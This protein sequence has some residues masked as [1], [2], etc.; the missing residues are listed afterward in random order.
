MAG[1]TPIQDLFSQQVCLVVDPSPVFL[2]FMKTALNN[3]ESFNLEL[4][5]S[6]SFREAKK[7]IETRKPRIV[8]VEHE[9]DGLKGLSLIEAQQQIYDESS[10]ISVIISQNSE[11]S[12]IA[13]AAEEQVDIFMLK[14]FSIDE[15]QKRLLALI[16]KK[17]NPTEYT[18]KINQARE[19][20]KEKSYS[21]ALDLLSDAKK[22]RDKPALA[23]FYRGDVYRAINDPRGALAEF[24]E[25]R[26]Y[27]SLHYKCIIG[28]FE[29]LMEEKEYQSA[30]NLIPTLVKNFPLTPKRLTQV[31]I[32]SVFSKHFEFLPDYYNQFLKMEQRSPELINVASAALIAGAKWQFQ[33]NQT[34]EGVSLFDKAITVVGREITVLDKVITDLIKFGAVEDAQEFLKKVKTEDIGT[35]EFNRISF[36]V[37]RQVLSTPQL[38]ERAR[39][40]VFSDQGTPEIFELVVKLLAQ[41]GKDSLAESVIEKAMETNP[42]LRKPLYK[43]LDDNKIVGNSDKSKL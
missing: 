9:I 36:K 22:L 2:I 23:C 38:L 31:F 32:A 13:E 21:S 33:K 19:L 25:G 18:L 15:F 11:D 14:P 5:L 42:E 30:N 8:I 35:P 3:I 43:I 34:K 39:K 20:I 41:A 27:N 6:K 37:D 1:E 12:V 24:A 29:V 10:R 17:N 26:T 28:E 4:I 7:I 16:Q 40:L